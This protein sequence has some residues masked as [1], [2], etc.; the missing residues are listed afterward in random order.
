[1]NHSGVLDKLLNFEN[2]LHN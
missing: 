2:D 1:M